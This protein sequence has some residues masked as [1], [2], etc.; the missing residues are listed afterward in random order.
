MGKQSIGFLRTASVATLLNESPATSWTFFRGTFQKL[1]L[2]RSNDLM[3]PAVVGR[4]YS[5]RFILWALGGP[6][7]RLQWP[8]LSILSV[9]P[10]D[11][12]KSA[13]QSTSFV[14][15]PAARIA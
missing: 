12:R 5:Q 2:L 15:L 1:Q 14:A 7:V 4:L 11:D 9:P 3:R 8:T 13:R 6:P 10:G